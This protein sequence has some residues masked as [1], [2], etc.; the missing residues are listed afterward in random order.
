LYHIEVLGQVL[1]QEVVF[2]RMMI[3][4]EQLRKTP[5]FTVRTVSLYLVCVRMMVAF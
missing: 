5:S 2:L 3:D 4:V 1:R